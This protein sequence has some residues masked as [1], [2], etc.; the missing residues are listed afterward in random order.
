MYLTVPR[1]E[2]QTEELEGS[3]VITSRQGTR[4]RSGYQNRPVLPTAANTLS[5]LDITPSLLPHN[6]SPRQT[7]EQQD[8]PHIPL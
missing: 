6:F 4:H 7:S 2:P 8:Y 1:M 5:I 3:K